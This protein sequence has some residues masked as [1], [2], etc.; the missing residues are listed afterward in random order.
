MIAVA[1]VLVLLGSLMTPVV[2]KAVSPATPGAGPA[3]A[4]ACTVKARTVDSINAV[5]STKETPQA[6]RSTS[7]EPKPYEK[8]KGSPVSDRTR[9]GVTATLAQFVACSNSGAILPLLALF[10]DNFLLDHAEE[11][12]LPFSPDDPALTPSPSPADARVNIASIDD[13]VKIGD[14]RVSAL[15]T[16]SVPDELSDTSL[17]QCFFTYNPDTKRWLIDQITLVIGPS[18][19]GG[20]SE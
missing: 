13:M 18:M 7:D 19:Y 11:M 9:K 8:P 5:V 17:L 16:L 12:G 4:V 15:V 20:D 6:G 10:S 1:I 2:E 14:G 3:P